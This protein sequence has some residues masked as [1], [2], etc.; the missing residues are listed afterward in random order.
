[1]AESIQKSWIEELWDSINNIISNYSNGLTLLDKASIKTK[2]TASDINDILNAKI[3]EIK[4]DEYLSQESS[5]FI[6]YTISQ[7]SLM[8]T[9]QKSQFDTMKN[10]WNAIVCKNTMGY[11]YG[12]CSHGVNSHTS[13][14]NGTNSV[15]CTKYG[16]SPNTY[17]DHKPQTTRKIGNSATPYNNGSN[18]YGPCPQG[19]HSHGT[20]SHGTCNPNTSIIDLRNSKTTGTK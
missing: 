1:M 14:G 10:N 6:A 5:L 15:A 18:N 3:A 11:S 12:I 7:G 16:T 9:A 13:K 19:E 20:C 2:P 4:A 17:G 8:T